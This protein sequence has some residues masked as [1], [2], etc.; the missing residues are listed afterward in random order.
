MIHIILGNQ[1]KHVRGTDIYTPLNQPCVSKNHVHFV[2][3]WRI[4]KI[5]GESGISVFDIILL[6]GLDSKS[7]GYDIEDLTKSKQ[8]N[9]KQTKPKLTSMAFKSATLYK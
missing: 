8:T 2:N 4:L 1:L 5:V 3:C 9:N 6:V 7:L